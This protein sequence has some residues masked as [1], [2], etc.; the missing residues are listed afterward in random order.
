[1]PVFG[2]IEDGN[3]SDKNVNNTVLSSISK[4][5]AAHGLGAG[6][7]IYIADSAVVTKKN[8]EVMGEEILFISRLPATFKE[9]DRVIKEAVSNDCWED[10]GVIAQ[11]KPTEKR[12]TAY[13]KFYETEVILYGKTYRAVVIH[14]S[15]HDRRRQKRIE[16]E[17][18]KEKK[19]LT[20]DA[21]KN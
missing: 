16:R 15:A 17:L 6:A 4:Y 20:L 13:Y 2:K 1:M 21:N 19:T 14:S 7:F 18:L 8:L 9:C 10:I 12:P 3:A 5:M 11:T